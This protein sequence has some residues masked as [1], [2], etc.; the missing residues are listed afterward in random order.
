[1]YYFVFLAL[2]VCMCGLTLAFLLRSA[3]QPPCHL[4]VP[5][6]AL[7][8]S[9]S[10]AID[11][12]HISLRSE[13]TSGN[14]GRAECIQR[15]PAGQPATVLTLAAALLP[16][17]ALTGVP[18]ARSTASV[19]FTLRRRRASPHTRPTERQRGWTRCCS[20]VGD[21]R[22]SWQSCRPT[23]RSERSRWPLS[24]ASGRA[25]RAVPLRLAR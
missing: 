25:S 6:A 4:R 22:S 5:S 16:P 24:L 17:A 7:F 3:A 10:A 21:C 2:L 9:D 23:Q 19:P 20:R 15:L 11:S 12:R 8:D 14:S 1:M 18:A 13:C